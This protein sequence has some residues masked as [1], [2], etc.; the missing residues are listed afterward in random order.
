M[1]TKTRKVLLNNNNVTI[2]N[3][4]VASTIPI[5][6]PNKNI[7]IVQQNEIQYMIN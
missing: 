3:N 6:N 1:L 4:K 5:Y 2:L 7:I